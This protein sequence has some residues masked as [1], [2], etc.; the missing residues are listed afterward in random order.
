MPDGVFETPLQ[1]FPRATGPQSACRDI[2]PARFVWVVILRG[3]RPYAVEVLRETMVHIVDEGSEF[4][5]PLEVVWKFLS[6]PMHGSAH[7]GRRNEQR[8]VVGE[9]VL[10]LSSEVETGGAYVKVTNR[11]T[12]YPPL[13]F[14]VEYLEG[15][16]AGSKAF[17]FYTPK[18]GKTAVSIV[19]EYV[20]KGHSSDGVNLLVRQMLNKFYEEDHAALRAYSR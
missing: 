8:R 9:S 11:I 13:G 19:G 12:L 1:V 15:P 20:A 18:G 3:Q 10:E 17:T 6:D 4:D 5:A 2:D 14:A 16:L 7:K